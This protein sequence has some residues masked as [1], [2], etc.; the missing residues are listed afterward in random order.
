MSSSQSSPDCRH[1]EGG[2]ARTRTDIADLYSRVAPA[3]VD[4]GPPFFALAGTRLVQVANVQLGD[5]VL[6]LGT[7]RGAV[8]IPAAQQVGQGGRALGV[9]I[10]PGMVEQTLLT[11][12]ELG[13]QHA[14]ARRMDVAHL[15]VEL[16]QFSHVLSSFSVFFFPDLPLLLRELRD[17]LSPSAVVGFAFSRGHDPRWTWYEDM[18]RNSGGLD[19]PTQPVGYPRVREAGVLV[20]LLDA[21]GFV[22]ISEHAETT[23]VWY[24]SPEAWW[25][26][27]WTHG[28]RRALERMPAEVLA[29]F[30]SASAA[31]VQAMAEPRGVLDQME[32]VYVIGRRGA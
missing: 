12:A 28:S 19:E 2:T 15:D 27:L 14:A 13:L 25:D 24:A 20:A 21:A 23:D 10:A 11:L 22:D 29:E 5:S 8:L 30:Q 6:D 31:R 7:G 1:A 18:L 4:K 32:M 26:S 16:S 9:D 17:R 3:Y